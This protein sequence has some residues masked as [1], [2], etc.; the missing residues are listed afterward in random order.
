MLLVGSGREIGKPSGEQ[1]DIV[2]D[3]RDWVEE[4][5]GERVRCGG[6]GWEKEELK[7]VEGD[8]ETERE[9]EVKDNRRK[10]LKIKNTF[11][12]ETV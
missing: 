10:H 4:V 1:N 7:E 11:T 8:S 9:R 3:L 6:G 5:D 12:C 2:E